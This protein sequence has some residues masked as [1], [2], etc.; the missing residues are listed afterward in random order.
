MVFSIQ[1][2]VYYAFTK[3]INTE[4]RK[5]DT[6]KKIIELRKASV[7]AL[8]AI[9]YCKN[10][11]NLFV[12]KTGYHQAFPLIIGTGEST[13]K[14]HAWPSKRVIK[15]DDIIMIDIGL[16]H[17][18][19]SDYASDLT[20][21]FFF[22]EPTNEQKKVYEI[23]KNAHDLAIKAVKIGVSASNVDKVARN[24]IKEHFNGYDIPHGVGHAVKRWDHAHP[25][26]SPGMNYELKK[27]DIITI[28]PGIYLEGKFGVRIEDLGVVTENGYEL[29]TKNR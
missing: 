20:R 11:K 16:K 3:V 21:T 5:V 7:I 9:N 14:I 6:Q 27:N 26:L 18:W 8:L 28:E 22:G 25:F 10:N 15:N 23:V 1:K 24:Y 12:G 17:S 13:S 29:L 2:S 4:F 19:I